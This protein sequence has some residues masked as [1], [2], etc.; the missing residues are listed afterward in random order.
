MCFRRLLLTALTVLACSD[1]ILW[2][3]GAD[4][5]PLV[6]GSSWRYESGG[7]ASFDSV[8]GDSVVLGRSARL[9][10]RD[11]APELWLADQSEVRRYDRRAAVI[12]GQEYVLLERWA[13]VYRL[14]LVTGAGW[15]ESFADTVVV[16]G[17]DS[18]VVRDSF[19]ARVS[20]IEDVV[21]PAGSF[22]QCY[23]IEFY[24]EYTG[25]DTVAE[26]YTEWLAPGVGVVRRTG[27]GSERVLT[28]W[29]IGSR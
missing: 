12:G 18:I 22:A 15:G 28:D 9:V 23:R 6:T 16:L 2:R 11:F 19:S 27:A 29:R 21:V 10:L 3:A 7:F 4:Y 13:L 8:A 17:S 5:F 25:I 1:M 20:A 14:P 26:Q 24:H